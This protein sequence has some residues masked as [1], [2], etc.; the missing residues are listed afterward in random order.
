M[1]KVE[2]HL[3]WEPSFP[4]Q[5][6][7]IETGTRK[8][9]RSNVE[10]TVTLKKDEVEIECSWDYGWEG[11]GSER[12]FIPLAQLKELIAELEAS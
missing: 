9:F 4:N 6:D 12:M 11:R 1:Q 2:K 8:A 3:D 10:F 7:I 5:I